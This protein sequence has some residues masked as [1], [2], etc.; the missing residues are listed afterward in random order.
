MAEVKQLLDRRIEAG[1][2]AKEKAAQ[3]DCMKM[4]LSAGDCR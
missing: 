1:K 4:R 3:I 2:I